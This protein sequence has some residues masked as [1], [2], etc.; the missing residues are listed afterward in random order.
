MAE[1]ADSP[2]TPLPPSTFP[3][4]SVMNSPAST[5]RQVCITIKSVNLNVRVLFG[6]I[7]WLFSPTPSP[8]FFSFLVASFFFVIKKSWKCWRSVLQP[9]GSR[10]MGCCRDDKLLS[11]KHNQEVASLNRCSSR[12]HKVIFSWDD[13][14]L[15]TRLLLFLLSKVLFFCQVVCVN[16]F[17]L[18]HP[19]PPTHPRK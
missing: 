4:H 1:S 12:T 2:P 16:S 10:F 13:Y 5:R 14:T 6:E 11:A 18:P 19:P 17:C 8:F 7:Y 15:E 3:G 9:C